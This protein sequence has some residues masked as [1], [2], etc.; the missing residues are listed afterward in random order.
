MCSQWGNLE[1][2]NS[3]NID[4]VSLKKLSWLQARC[5]KIAQKVLTL[6]EKIISRLG[7]LQEN[8]KLELIK[9]R[10]GKKAVQAYGPHSGKLK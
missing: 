8:L 2:L 6:D 1:V 3:N 9:T 5:R 4:P 10:T 7:T